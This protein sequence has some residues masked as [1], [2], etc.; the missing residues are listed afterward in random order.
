MINKIIIDLCDDFII[1]YFFYKDIPMQNQ[2]IYFDKVQ[3]SYNP[4]GKSYTLH[5]TKKIEKNYL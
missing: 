3:V 5:I 2:I 1:Q 4:I